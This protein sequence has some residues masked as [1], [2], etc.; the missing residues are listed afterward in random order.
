MI[1]GF[2][3]SGHVFEPVVGY[4]CIFQSGAVAVQI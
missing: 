4:V 2:A 1:A 3:Q